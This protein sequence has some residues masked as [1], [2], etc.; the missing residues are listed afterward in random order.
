MYPLTARCTIVFKMWKKKKTVIKNLGKV[1]V[2]L[3]DAGINA[4]EVWRIKSLISEGGL[5]NFLK[6]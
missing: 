6:L 2:V 5:D 4:L 1:V 3:G